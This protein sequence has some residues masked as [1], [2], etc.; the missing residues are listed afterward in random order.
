MLT[1]VADVMRPA[2]YSSEMHKG[3]GGKENEKRTPHYHLFLNK[4][5]KRKRRK[6]RR[7]LA[8][9]DATFQASTHSYEKRVERLTAY[10]SLQ[11]KR[12]REDGLFFSPCAAGYCTTAIC[13]F[14]F[15][16]VADNQVMPG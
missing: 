3:G 12:L 1:K 14:F 9:G 11:K 10:E 7:K 2:E 8:C 5:R 4:Y 6:E 16:I 15:L 13:V